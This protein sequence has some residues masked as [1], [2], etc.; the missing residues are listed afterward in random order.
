MDS[1]SP[2]ASGLVSTQ[3]LAEH[4]THP[5]V[6]IVEVS[7]DRGLYASHGH[8]A[9]AV[10]WSGEPAVTDPIRRPQ[11]FRASMERLLARSGIDNYSTVVLYGDGANAAAVRA[12]WCL[13]LCGHADA[14]LLDGGRDGWV[15]EGHPLSTAAAARVQATYRAIATNGSYRA[16]PRELRSAE[17][18]VIDAGAE[19]S[20]TGAVR[21]PWASTLSGDGTLQSAA[22]LE[23][24]FASRGITREHHI[25]T[26][27]PER[28]AA[29][30]VWF[31]LSRV[32][33]FPHVRNCE[34]V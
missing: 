34:G 17:S 10:D 9:G 14:R 1:R 4:F 13:T 31:A 19:A 28:G 30:H 25:V 20:V 3:W 27:S 12:L 24:L 29:A 22:A 5:H 6:A 32:L 8:I 11:R 16:K 21:V 2:L 7:V 15:R 33:G 23:S 18:I 26:C